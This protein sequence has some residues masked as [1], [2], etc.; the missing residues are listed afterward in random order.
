MFGKISL[1]GV[2]V[3]LLLVILPQESL[4][5]QQA[6]LR[7]FVEA[8]IGV[9]VE[10]PDNV[11]LNL[12]EKGGFFMTIVN[13]GNIRDKIRVE[14]VLV[15]KN[16]WVDFAFTCVGGL[17]ECDDVLSSQAHSIDQ[18]ELTPEINSTTV[19]VEMVGW[20]KTSTFARANK[21]VLALTGF[22]L[23]NSTKQSLKGIDIEVVDPDA[24]FGPLAAPEL[25]FYALLLLFVLVGVVAYR[26]EV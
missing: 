5:Q 14:G 20:R 11:V 15:P 23:T 18:I 9:R 12:G 26:I 25:N 4:A 22:S 13:E 19:F 3:L 2:P 7:L 17:G 21:P 8:S 16:E 6:E 1:F 24:G 10:A